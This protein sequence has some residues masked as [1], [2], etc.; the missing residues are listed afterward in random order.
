MA[1]LPDINTANVSYIA[2]WN[3][4]EDGG[5]LEIDPEEALSAGSLQS[6]TLYDNGWEGQ[7]SINGHREATVR[8]KTDG[9]T[10]A[11]LDRSNDYTQNQSYATAGTWDVLHNWDDSYFQTQSE[12]TNNALARAISSL[13]SNLSN[14]GSIT[15]SLADVRLY[16]Y[17]Y[18]NTT[19]VTMLS[20]NYR[21]ESGGSDHAFL[22][23]SDTTLDKA[24][25]VAATGGNA[26]SATFEG[27]TIS[28]SNNW[29]SAD[30]LSQGL[31]PNAETEY[32]YS[33]GDTNYD[34]VSV[35]V[36]LNWY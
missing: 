31:I 12:L 29:G 34:S 30:L 20:A 18:P 7:Y 6:Y 10:V 23:T 9:W 15:F 27:L 21:D 4:I 33:I 35:A 19:T 24:D 32:T 2:Y 14:S 28:G 26:A 22:Y 8:M 36:L 3:A 17:E 11:Y 1:E 13:R 5:A 16:D 25:A